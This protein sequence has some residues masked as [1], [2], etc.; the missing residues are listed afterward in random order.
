MCIFFLFTP[1]FL[2][3]SFSMNSGVCQALPL[4]TIWGSLICSF[5]QQRFCGQCGEWDRDILRRSRWPSSPPSFMKY[6]GGVRVGEAG[7]KSRFVTPPLSVWGRHWTLVSGFRSVAPAAFSCV[8]VVTPIS[9]SHWNACL[10]M[11]LSFH[12]SVRQLSFPSK[13]T[14]PMLIILQNSPDFFLSF[15]P[16]YQLLSFVLTVLT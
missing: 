3:N 16:K 15:K 7:H 6:P 5:V 4:R 10:L 8:S 9:F 2:G 14:M 13:D 11:F 12:F 1:A